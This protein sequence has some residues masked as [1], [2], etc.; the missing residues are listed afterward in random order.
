[1]RNRYATITALGFAALLMGFAFVTSAQAFRGGSSD[2]TAHMTFTHA[3]RVP[4][5]T[6]PAGRYVFRLYQSNTVVLIT[7]ED[8]GKVFGPYMT[9][10]RRYRHSRLRDG[11]R[12]ILVDRA[13]NE[14]GVPVI[15]AWFGRYQTRGY[16]FVYPTHG[17]N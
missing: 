10:A 5:V 17:D 6:L 7:S 9:Q 15:R 8:D 2:G 13:A 1:M 16:E 14:S 3:V 4:G 11:R 12:V